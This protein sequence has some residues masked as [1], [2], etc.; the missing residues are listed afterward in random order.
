MR[1]YKKNEFFIFFLIIAFVTTLIIRNRISNNLVEQLRLFYVKMYV[2]KN[3]V[4]QIL[5]VNSM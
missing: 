5:N 3:C 2:L 4:D 1:F